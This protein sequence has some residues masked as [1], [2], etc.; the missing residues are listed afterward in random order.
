MS[1]TL[2]NHVPDPLAAELDLPEPLR[3]LSDRDEV[4]L[5]E[6]VRASLVRVIAEVEQ[7]P[8]SVRVAVGAVS[9]EVEWAPERTGDRPAPVAPPVVALEPVAVEQSAVLSAPTVGVFYRSPEPGAAPFVGPGDTVVVGQ[10]VGIV[11]AMK[12]MIPV[13][14]EAAGVVVEVL[15]DDGAAVEYGE[16]L[17]TLSTSG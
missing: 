8:R 15:K 11:E 1:Q 16:P 6:R 13:E 5:L 2:S 3:Q 12:L 14:A 9:V 7:H 17:I 10:Q 4:D